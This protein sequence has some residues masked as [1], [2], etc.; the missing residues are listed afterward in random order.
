MK[1]KGFGGETGVLARPPR[2]AS[3]NP[4]NNFIRKPQTEPMILHSIF[5]RRSGLPLR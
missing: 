1:E 2:T 3:P 5:G 4:K